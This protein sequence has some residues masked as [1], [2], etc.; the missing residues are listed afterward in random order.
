MS[1]TTL[2][3]QNVIQNVIQ[4]LRSKKYL[5]SPVKI[6]AIYLAILFIYFKE[7]KDVAKYVGDF[8]RQ[9][10]SSK[11]Y[12]EAMNVLNDFVK[13][14]ERM[15]LGRELAEELEY[16]LYNVFRGALHTF[17]TRRA[18]SIIQAVSNKIKVFQALLS[19]STNTVN[20]TRAGSFYIVLSHDNF[21]SREGYLYLKK[22][23][24]S[25]K[26]FI[27]L[28]LFVIVIPEPIGYGIIVPAPYVDTYIQRL[29]ASLQ[30]V[31]QQTV[32]IVQAPT[33]VSKEREVKTESKSFIPENV[34]LSREILETIVTK[35]FESFGFKVQVNALLPAR[36]G[37]VEV[38]IWASKKIGNALFTVYVSC[39]NWDRDVDRHVLDHEFGRI[40]QLYQLPHLRILVVKSL[41]DPARK[42]ALDNG[43]I[44]I[45]LG[46][47]ATSQNAQEVYNIVYNKLKETFLGLAL[48]IL[49]SLSTKI[50]SLADEIKKIGYELGKA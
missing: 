30:I 6:L 47:K 31:S 11:E 21:S 19:L 25:F 2:A 1:S 17:I 45:E 33:Q 41:S 49:Q 28:C 29:T 8:L 36:G 38:D 12:E 42:L 40:L 34:L 22:F 26:E 48:P 3:P 16:K 23:D 32:S 15:Q 7:L 14:V 4:T 24:V 9:R 46:E 10:L 35:V 43:F 5:K 37:Y 13:L 20:K 27:D 18:G 39:K 44:V 50:V